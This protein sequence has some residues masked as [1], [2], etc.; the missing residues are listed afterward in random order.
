MNDTSIRDAILRIAREFNTTGLSAGTT[1]NSSV[2][3]G[4]N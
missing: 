4:I 2:C 1:G 3:S